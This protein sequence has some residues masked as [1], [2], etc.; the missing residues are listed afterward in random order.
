MLDSESS[1]AL[2]PTY[3]GVLSVSRPSSSSLAPPQHSRQCF[4]ASRIVGFESM[5]GPPRRLVSLIG[6]VLLLAAVLLT[7]HN[8]Y[9][10]SPARPWPDVF[11]RPDVGGHLSDPGRGQLGITEEQLREDRNGL[12]TILSPEH[13]IH[14]EASTIRL[15][16]NIT[17]ADLAPDG[18]RRQVYLINGMST[19]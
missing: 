11:L 19:S 2:D 18:V 12:R 8:V 15:R 17:I 13:H 1:I 4:S 7:L 3:L 9:Y 16:W 6:A 14:R 10:T 5:G